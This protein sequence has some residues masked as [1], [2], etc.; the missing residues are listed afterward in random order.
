MPYMGPGVRVMSPYGSC[1]LAATKPRVVTAAPRVSAQR[2]VFWLEDAPH[3][4]ICTDGLI[5]P[6]G[7][8]LMPLP[9]QSTVQQFAEK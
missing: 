4:Q 1:W 7:L 5:H 8:T 9:L 3:R 6:E 2:S